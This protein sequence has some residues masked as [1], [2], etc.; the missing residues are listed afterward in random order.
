[1][2]RIYPVRNTSGLPGDPVNHPMD[3]YDPLVPYQMVPLEGTRDM[4]VET[5]NFK[6]QLR[7]R[8]HDIVKL[9][10]LRIVRQAKPIP[11][12]LP[13]PGVI[14]VPEHSLVQ[15]TI[16]PLKDGGTTVLEGSDWPERSP[17]L[18]PEVKLQLS[19]K[20]HQRREFA[21]CYLF[22]RAGNFDRGSR[23]NFP[24]HFLEVNDIFETQANIRIVNADGPASRTKA[25]RKILMNGT[26]GKHFFD[27]DND[28]LIGKIVDEFD[29]AFPGVSNRMHAVVFSVPIPI[30]RKSNP[31]SRT[32]G[33]NMKWTRKK[34]GQPFNVLFVGPVSPPKPATE[35]GFQWGQVPKFR[36]V[37]AHEIG[38]SLGL[39]H[40]PDFGPIPLE[41]MDI[42]IEE[43]NPAF[44]I[45]APNRNLMFPMVLRSNRLNAIQIETM[46]EIG[47]D[48][49]LADI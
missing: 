41:V 6:A 43:F 8:F 11:F 13:P 44:F 29:K 24:G 27:R 42:L 23:R 4:F 30:G 16:V 48:F 2:P 21:V 36:H 12:P 20:R 19:V 28:R 46:H 47:P 9:T 17:P 40:H 3:G 15:L 32:L 45:Q 25:A 38:H 14:V 37:L 5:F 35:G 33:F 7:L 10:N 39:E 31:E 22:D 49:P 18:K 26:L 34:T 1:M